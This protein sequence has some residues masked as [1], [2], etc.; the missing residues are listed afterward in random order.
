MASRAELREILITSR[1]SGSGSGA[2]WTGPCPEAREPATLREILENPLLRDYVEELG[3]CAAAF[4]GKPV[5]SLPFGSY[6]MF[7]ESGDR[8]RF[9]E[10]YFERRRGLVATGLASWLFGRA[11]DIAALE[12]LI[13]AICDEYTWALPAHLEGT[14]LDIRCLPGGAEAVHPELL[15][16]FSCETAFALAEICCLLEG[17]LTPIVAERARR[18]L[19]RRVL[20]PFLARAKPWRWE[21]MR[22]NWCAVC[23]GSVGAAALYLVR[24][25]DELAAILARVLPTLE[26]FLESFADD[27]TCLEGLGYWTYGVGFFASFADLLER[28]TGGRLDLMANEKF[29]RVASFQ[30]SCYLN[31]CMAVSFADGS[32]QERY[33]IGLADYLARRFPEA[34]PPPRALAAGFGHDHNGRWCLS[35]RDLLWARGAACPAAEAEVPAGQIGPTYRVVIGVECQLAAAGQPDLGPPVWLPDA[36]WLLCPARK[37][38]SLAFAAKGGHNDEPHNHNDIGSFELVLGER[39]LLADLGRGEYTRDY[40]N[41]RRYSIFCNS[42][43]GHNLP[44]VGGQGQMEGAGHRARNVEFRRE[45]KISILTMD[46]APAYGCEALLR[47]TR[48]FEFDGDGA[49]GLRLRDEFEF[50]R[51]GVEVIERFVTPCT[52]TAAREAGCFLVDA[53]GSKARALLVSCSVPGC[54]ARLSSHGHREH[55]GGMSIVTGLDY[56]MGPA[57]TVFFCDFEFSLVLKAGDPYTCSPAKP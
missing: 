40:F 52:V 23:A 37:E 9:E 10:P 22:N 11:E 17:R 31:E 6:R 18:E 30:K 47:L 48:R 5:A 7:D 38:G 32:A 43:F 57:G 50:S 3:R 2:G 35:F 19:R 20:V 14:S 26:R 8:R 45:G 42:S 29:R 56:H 54:A 34:S 27:G 53:G 41:E 24:D 39:Q 36:Q 15:D 51:P 49:G 1:R 46:I 12:D 55:E 25:L 13:W 28:E 21:L 4:H 16:L 44:I 33:R